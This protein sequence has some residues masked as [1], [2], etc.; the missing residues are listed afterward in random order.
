MARQEIRGTQF[1][2]KKFIFMPPKFSNGGYTL[3]L[4]EVIFSQLMHHLWTE[5]TWEKKVI[6]KEL[7]IVKDDIENSFVR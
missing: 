5:L 1:I 6:D 4:K 7:W 2:P 3:L